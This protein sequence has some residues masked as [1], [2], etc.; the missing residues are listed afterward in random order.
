MHLPNQVVAAITAI[1]IKKRHVACAL[2]LVAAIM[3]VAKNQLP[4]LP[5]PIPR[6]NIGFGHTQPAIDTR[7]DKAFR[8]AIKQIHRHGEGY[9]DTQVDAPP[10]GLEEVLKMAVDSSHSGNPD[11][12]YL[13]GWMLETHECLDLEYIELV[14]QVTRMFECNWLSDRRLKLATQWYQ[15][16][17]EHGSIPAAAELGYMYQEGLGAPVNYAL[18]AKWYQKAV[19][20]GDGQA[21]IDLGR[22]YQNG[23]GMNTDPAK[24]M[25]LYE[26]AA[27]GEC[28]TQARVMVEILWAIYGTKPSKK[29]SKGELN[30]FDFVTKYGDF[31]ETGVLAQL[32]DTP[33]KFRESNNDSAIQKRL[34]DPQKAL[35]LYKLSRSQKSF[36]ANSRSEAQFF[37]EINQG[38]EKLE[39]SPEKV[40]Q[41]HI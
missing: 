1:T 33:E 29:L 21:Q 10:L 17:C 9:E 13:I 8:E 35:F 2:A 16:A 39:R 36:P 27:N 4:L 32:Y 24:A 37:S 18:A 5:L 30:A 31:W 23:L 15:L 26:E 19:T 40:E 14:N 3:L 38:I 6:P 28:S 11:A 25:T 41:H 20:A 12:E 7:S 22:M 34:H